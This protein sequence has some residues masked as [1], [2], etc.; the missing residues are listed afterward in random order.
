MHNVD[1]QDLDN[2]AHHVHNPSRDLVYLVHN[3]LLDPRNRW[4][5]YSRN[6]NR[7]T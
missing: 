5:M 7:R 4:C 2:R 1:M 3:S 6:R